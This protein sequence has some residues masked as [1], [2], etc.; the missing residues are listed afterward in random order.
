MSVGSCG[1]AGRGPD[2]MKRNNHAKIADLKVHLPEER[3]PEFYRGRMV[4][5]Q[6]LH[7]YTLTSP[8]RMSRIE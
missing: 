4:V 7:V 3:K 6:S 2:R 5:L 1:T 8:L